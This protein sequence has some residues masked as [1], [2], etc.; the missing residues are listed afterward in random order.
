MLGARVYANAEK[1]IGWFPFEMIGA[2]AANRLFSSLPQWLEV[3]H[4]HGDTL[5]LPAGSVHLARSAGCAY[6]AFVYDER[7]VGLQ[8]HLEATPGSAQSLISHCAVEIAEGRY[9]QS[10]Q[11]ILADACRFDA[12]THAMHRFLDRIAAV[13]SERA[14]RADRSAS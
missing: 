5:D 3:F 6:Q 14:T 11:D 9:I 7:V 12:I 8:F 2:A 1:E 10:P 4:W 13:S